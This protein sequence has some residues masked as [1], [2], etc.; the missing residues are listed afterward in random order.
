MSFLE[1]IGCEVSWDVMATCIF[2]EISV[3]T[4]L[5]EGHLEDAMGGGKVLEGGGEKKTSRRTPLPKRGLG[6]PFVW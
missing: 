2:Q 1:G 3:Q 6:P 5:S 4:P